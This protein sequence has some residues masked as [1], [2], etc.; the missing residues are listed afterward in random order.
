MK[1]E[2]KKDSA[3]HPIKTE[4]DRSYSELFNSLLNFTP[5]GNFNLTDSSPYVPKQ[6]SEAGTGSTEPYAP[7]EIKVEQDIHVTPIKSILKQHI[8]PV[9]RAKSLPNILKLKTKPLV[10]SLS[11][12]KINNPF[13]IDKAEN[14]TK[15]DKIDKTNK[16][17]KKID[18]FVNPPA[19]NV[20]PMKLRKEPTRLNMI[21]RSRKKK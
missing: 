18:K 8:S 12:L 4:T 6:P 11:N 21:L 19:R 14:I 10:K 16:T 20:H 3:S 7:V 5:V 9:R 17:V 2:V 15:I 1:A 13:K